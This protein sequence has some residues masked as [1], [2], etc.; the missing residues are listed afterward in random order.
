MAFRCLWSSDMTK[1]KW[2]R[3][4]AT[5]TSLAAV[6]MSSVTP[7]KSTTGSALLRK[8]LRHSHRLNAPVSRASPLAAVVLGP[9][10]PLPLVPRGRRAAPQGDEGHFS[11]AQPCAAASSPSLRRCW[12][13]TVADSRPSPVGP[14]HGA[15]GCPRFF[16]KPGGTTL[17]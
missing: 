2:E 7:W 17:S 8:R 4:R 15:A 16:I 6:F 1:W 14:L 3:A 13:Q 11:P 10:R 5:R 12:E 9:G